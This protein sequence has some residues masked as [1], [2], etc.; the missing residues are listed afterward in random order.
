MNRLTSFLAFALPVLAGLAAVAWVAAGYA[1]AYPLALAVTLAVGAF[2][3]LG[4]AE[5]HRYRQASAHLWRAALALEQSPAPALASWL[6]SLPAPLREPVRQRVH[7]SRAPWAGPA[8]APY[9]AALLVLL[10]MLGTFAGMVVTLRGTGLAL[11]SAADLAA[12]RA[13][14]AAPVKGLGVAFGTS[15]AG[16][17][18]SAMLGLLSALARRERQQAGQQ[19]DARIA[20]ALHPHTPAHQRE[21]AFALMQRQADSLPQLAEQLHAVATQMQQQHAELQER[22][23]ASQDRFHTQAEAA[24]TRLAQSVEHSLQRSLSESAHAAS[25]ALQPALHTT[26]EGLAQQ[27]SRLQTGLNE[28]VRQQWHSLT[29]RLDTHHADVARHWNQALT[30]QQHAHDSLTT[31]LGDTLNAFAAGFAQRTDTLLTQ[32]A[33]QLADAHNQLA[34]QSQQLLQDTQHTLASAAQQFAQHAHTLQ[35]NAAQAHTALHTAA[36]ERDQQQRAAWQDLLAAHTQ[37]SQQHSAS[38]RQALADSAAALAAQASAL[39]QGAQ[40]SFSS[41]QTQAAERDAQQLAAWQE[42][43]A[44]HAR[45]AHTQTSATRQALESATQQFE[46]HA[47]T[48]QESVAQAHA[49]L[50]EQLAEQETQRLTAWHDGLA[51]M[52]S[53]LH[54][55]WQHASAEQARQQQAMC[56]TLAATAQRIVAEAASQ[57]QTAAAHITSLMDAAAAAPRAAAEVMDELRTRLAD[58]LARDNAM[59]DERAR[60]LHT[61]GGLADTLTHTSDQQRQAIDKLLASTSERLDQLAAQFARHTEEGSARLQDAA[62]HIGAGAAEIASLGD[63]FGQAVQRFGDSSTQLGAHLQQ[64]DATLAQSIARSDEQLAYYVAQA[65]EVIDLSLSAQ[66]QVVSDLQRLAHERSASLP[67]P[68]A[69]SAPA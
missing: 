8:L 3:M 4:V 30:S 62:A 54:E 55:Q 21:Q 26:L 15:L 48:L 53:Q 65:R 14:L 40:H 34:S 1:G 12:V 32:A 33:G 39:L 46:Q 52:A 6:D 27:A 19:L 28:Q 23:L 5:L 24:Y 45:T 42:A 51:R 67:P 49:A 58:S 61:L 13:S 50:R 38:T 17:A 9:L 35:E 7:G 69:E 10:G 60:L 41:A 2:F 20:T 63:A 44:E 57:Q 43:L 68:A 66:Q 37:A 36:A 56:D 59:L 64:L 16:V 31:R 47:R 22:L 18:T 25:A 11:E 29:E